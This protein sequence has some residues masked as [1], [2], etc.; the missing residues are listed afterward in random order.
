MVS[1]DIKHHGMEYN[2]EKEILIMHEYGRNVQMLVD[3]AKT[4]EN[5]EERQAFANKIVTLMHQMHPNNRTIDDY[6]DKLWKHLFR[7]A[8]FDIE[9]DTP[10]GHTPTEV[11]MRKSPDRVPYPESRTRFRHYG[12]NVKAMID[13]AIAM[14]DGPKKD[15][16]V[17]VIGSY[18]KL[19]YKTWAREHY[20]SDEII[21]EDLISL[22]KG[23]LKLNDNIY[24]DKLANAKPRKRKVNSDNRSNN[25]DRR[26]NYR[27]NNNRG[28]SSNRGGGGYKGR[29]K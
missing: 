18:M 3:H 16:Y 14:P 27:G 26:N 25:N 28:G 12:N 21:K 29:R 23:K 9:V 4:I 15:G 7:I 17:A 6:L 2:S 10:S 13:N 11:E 24:L 22:S 20:V 19:A 8:K 1:K 5:I